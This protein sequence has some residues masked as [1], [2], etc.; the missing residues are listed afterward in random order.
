MSQVVI[1]SYKEFEQYLN[2]PIGVSDYF[3][4]TQEQVNRFAG[5][6][7]DHQWIHTDPERAAK[8]SP[9]K[10]PIAHGYLMLSIAPFLWKQVANIINIKMMIN[11]GIEKFKFNQPVLVGDE[12]RL[13]VK[14]Q[15]LAD[16]RGITRCKL[17]VELEIKGNKKPAYSGVLVFLYHFIN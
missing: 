11:Y 13:H 2:Q 17:H 14:L 5:A 8:E 6:T 4:I 3:E 1:G 7:N 12:V 16:L 10:A 9:F 15:E